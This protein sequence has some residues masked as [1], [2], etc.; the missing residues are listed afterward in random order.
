M[1]ACLPAGPATIEACVRD[2]LEAEEARNLV[3][4][5]LAEI[6]LYLE[7]FT[8]FC[9]TRKII[10]PQ[11]IT[12]VLCKDFVHS[13]DHRRSPART[14]TVVWIVRKFGAW[15]ALHHFLPDNP[16]TALHHPRLWPRKKLPEYLAHP[17]N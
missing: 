7:Q 13:F 1:K 12:P 17:R 16:A 2:C 15:L 8:G 10:K 9:R 3:P 6:K 11:A 5:S 14:K 4:R